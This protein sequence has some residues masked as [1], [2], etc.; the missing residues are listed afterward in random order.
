[1]LES[2][3]LAAKNLSS[4]GIDTNSTLSNKPVFDLVISDY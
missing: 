1:M 3:A 4:L 2:D